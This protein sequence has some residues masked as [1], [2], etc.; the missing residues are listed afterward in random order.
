M[1]RVGNRDTAGSTECGPHS[2]I[3]ARAV[4]TAPGRR[5]SVLMRV[6]IG[7][8]VSRASSRGVASWG[9]VSSGA[10]VLAAVVDDI[11]RERREDR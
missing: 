4:A 9:A 1:E 5:T 11:S 6:S 3:A 10:A 7:L 8:P 2:I